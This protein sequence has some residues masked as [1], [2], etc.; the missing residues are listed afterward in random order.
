M[1]VHPGEQTLIHLPVPYRHLVSL[2]NTH[3]TYTPM[4]VAREFSR[5]AIG[6]R[7]DFTTSIWERGVFDL[8]ERHFPIPPSP[9]FQ[10][11]SPHLLNPNSS[12]LYE[13]SSG[14]ATPTDRDDAERNGRTRRVRGA[15][16]AQF[17]ANDTK[18][19]ADASELIHP[20]VD[21]IDLNL[22]EYP[23]LLSHLSPINER[24]TNFIIGC[25]QK[26]AYAEKIGSYLLREPDTVR[27]LIRA[28]RD[29]TGW[30]TPISIKIRLDNELERTERLVRTGKFDS[31]AFI[32]ALMPILVLS[33]YA[34]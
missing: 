18:V 25:P 3:I 5:S 16:I 32:C 12:T 33:D 30:N 9:P 21:G 8:P 26:W 28:A 13:G 27:D 14:L 4:I 24:R 2:Y 15:L 1:T 10:V 6:R 20:H 23:L 22:G 7:S 11:E 31:S 34:F 29:R 19:F 17:A